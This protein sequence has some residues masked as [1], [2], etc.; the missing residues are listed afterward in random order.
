MQKAEPIWALG[1]MSG[2][3]LDGVDAAMVL[4]DGERILDLGGTDLDNREGSRVTDLIDIPV[5]WAEPDAVELQGLES[6][7][8]TDRSLDLCPVCQ[9][10]RMVRQD[11]PSARLPASTRSPP[12]V[13]PAPAVGTS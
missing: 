4:T 6:L 9:Q 8:L 11:L 2:T 7:E 10:G 13:I 1:A 3:S 12:T 5:P